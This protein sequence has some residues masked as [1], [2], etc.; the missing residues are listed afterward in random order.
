[1]GRHDLAALTRKIIKLWYLGHWDRGSVP[2]PAPGPDDVVPSSRELWEL[3]AEDFGLRPPGALPAEHP[4]PVD[5]AG[6]L[7]ELLRCIAV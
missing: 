2:P 4:Q 1:M 5:C 6:A 3:R 7:A